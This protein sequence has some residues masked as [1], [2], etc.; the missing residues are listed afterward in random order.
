MEIENDAEDFPVPA[1]EGEGYLT[2][3]WSRKRFGK[4]WLTLRTGWK[5]AC[6]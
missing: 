3:I 1:A 5:P 6:A 2:D 4:P